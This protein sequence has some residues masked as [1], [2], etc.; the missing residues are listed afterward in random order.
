[1]T[2]II[3]VPGNWAKDIEEREHVEQMCAQLNEGT[4]YQR[5]V[6]ALRRMGWDKTADD[7]VKDLA[8]QGVVVH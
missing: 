2:N 3:V 4:F 8:L 7:L 5:Q 1:M 6:D